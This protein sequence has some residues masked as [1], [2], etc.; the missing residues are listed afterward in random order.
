MTI[1][2]DFD[3]NDMVELLAH[4]TEQHESERDIIASCLFWAVAVILIIRGAIMLINGDDNVL[5]VVLIIL[6]IFILLFKIFKKKL[7]ENFLR[8][9]LA[10]QMDKKLLGPV[11]ITIDETSIVSVNRLKRRDINWSSI[12]KTEEDESFFFIYQTGH[13]SLIIPKNKIAPAE[14][15]ELRSLL[16]KHVPAGQGQKQN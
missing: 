4:Q 8:K 10:K 9:T 15:E 2:F 11:E 7:S 3:I 5:P 14:V 1:R 6:G 16:K 13:N 12:S